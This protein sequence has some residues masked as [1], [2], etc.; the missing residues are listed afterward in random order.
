MKLLYIGGTGEISFDCIHESVRL[1]HEVHVFNRGNHNDGLPSGVVCHTGDL[2]DDTAY[3]KLGETQWDVVCQFRLFDPSKLQRDLEV[4]GGRCGQY[5]FISS[6]SAYQKW[7]A[8]GP[9]TEDTPI[10]NPHWGYSQAK[11]EIEWALAA[12]QAVRY[13][14][15]RPS[16]TCRRWFPSGPC[17][18]E[19]DV[20]RMLQ[21]KPVLL[22]GDGTAPWALTLGRDFAVPFVRLLGHERAIG[23]AFHITNGRS[24]TWRQIY[25]A[26]GRVI[27][28]EPELAC[29]PTETL[30]RYVPGW[31]GPLWGDKTWPAVHDQSKLW[32]VVGDCQADTT[33]DGF[34]EVLW[35]EMQKVMAEYEHDTERD[36]LIDRIIAEQRALGA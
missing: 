3:A 23:E 21:G 13:T 34:F 24:W 29:V 6:A 30:L 10:G 15:V 22:H 5:V 8:E 7:A 35:P 33:L 26:M 20:H 32:S 2:N 17:S 27:G 14:I 12:Q 31:K 18:P 11:A 16:H 1:G 25:A 36:A 19:F 28:V 9:V 4:F